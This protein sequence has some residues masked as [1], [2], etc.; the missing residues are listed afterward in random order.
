[1]LT[2]F[3]KPNSPGLA[4]YSTTL[5]IPVAPRGQFR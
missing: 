1:V 3:I 5:T 2:A 4:S